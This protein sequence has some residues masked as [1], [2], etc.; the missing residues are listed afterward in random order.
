MARSTA[1]SKCILA[2]ALQL[3][4]ARCEQGG[5]VHDVGQ[6]RPGNGTQKEH[7]RTKNHVSVQYFP[8]SALRYCQG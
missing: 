5:L 3:S 8:H 1:L 2:T 7:G 4:S 6:V